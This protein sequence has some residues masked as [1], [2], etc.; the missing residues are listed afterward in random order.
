MMNGT[1]TIK[2]YAKNELVM[3]YRGRKFEFVKQL[4]YGQPVYVCDAPNDLL[5]RSLVNIPPYTLTPPVIFQK[6]TDPKLFRLVGSY[7]KKIS[8]MGCPYHFV[9]DKKNVYPFR[10][11]LIPEHHA[12]ILIKSSG[13]LFWYAEDIENFRKVVQKQ[14]KQKKKLTNEIKYTV[15]TVDQAEEQAKKMIESGDQRQLNEV[16][17]DIYTHD[18]ARMGFDVIPPEQLSKS[19]NQKKTPK[20]FEELKKEKEKEEDERI[21]N[22]ITGFS[23][24]IEQGRQSVKIT[25]KLKSI[26]RLVTPDDLPGLKKDLQK[27]K[28]KTS[29]IDTG[30]FTVQKMKNFLRDNIFTIDELQMMAD[31]ELQ[32]LNRVSIISLIREEIKKIRRGEKN[33]IKN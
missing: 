17:F 32:D 33:A 15:K 23:K 14:V 9:P 8:V 16:L 4:H 22:K 30:E 11:A 12:K 26:Q 13:H 1:K 5:S 19:L 2:I 24:L 28:P 21:K 31:N 3:S 18:A 10:L 27:L 25:E 6:K 20:T 7:V 29:N